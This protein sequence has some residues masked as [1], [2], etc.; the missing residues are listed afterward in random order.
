MEVQSTAANGGIYN[1]FE[2]R[3]GPINVFAMEY[4][5]KLRRDFTQIRHRNSQDHMTPREEA[6]P[7]LLTPITELIKADSKMGTCNKSGFH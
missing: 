2:S 5:E 4:S 7:P 6:T 1:G 3:K